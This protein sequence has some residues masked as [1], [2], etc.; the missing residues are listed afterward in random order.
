MGVKLTLSIV[1][2]TIFNFA[3]HVL[4]FSFFTSRLATDGLSCPAAYAPATMT[5]LNW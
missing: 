4:L 2:D 1:P 3:V 5:I